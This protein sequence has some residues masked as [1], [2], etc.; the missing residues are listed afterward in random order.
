MS[1]RAPLS[2][3][4]T[5]DPENAYSSQTYNDKVVFIAGAS[6]GIGEETALTYARAGASVAI[7]GRKQ[8]TLDEVKNAILQAAPKAAILTIVVD[9]TNTEQVESAAKAIVDRFGKLD[10][11]IANAGSSAAF[12]KR[13]SSV[14]LVALP[15]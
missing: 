13:T 5:I 8:A 2:V 10:V 3:Y 7:G 12:G 9:V 14:R 6:R 11:V 15:Y 4:P 1:F